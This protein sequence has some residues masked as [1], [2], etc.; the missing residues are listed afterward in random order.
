MNRSI[1]AR[2]M[3][4]I[5][6]AIAVFGSAAQEKVETLPPPTPLVAPVPVPVV[7]VVVPQWHRPNRDVWQNYAVN[8]AGQMRARVLAPTSFTAYYYYNGQPYL[9]PTVR[10]HNYVPFV[11]D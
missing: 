3:G 10:Q 6:C 9:T 1:E 2:P 5:V 4:C 8:S 7:V 11:T